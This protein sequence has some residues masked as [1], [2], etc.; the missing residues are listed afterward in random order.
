MPY[1]RAGLE[2]ILPV[3]KALEAILPV[4]KALEA[5]L[6][7]IALFTALPLYGP[8]L[9]HLAVSTV[10]RVTPCRLG[11]PVIEWLCRFRLRAREKGLN[12]LRSRVEGPRG[13][14]RLYYSQEPWNRYTTGPPL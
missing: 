7:A 10:L 2:A 6:P 5:I 12:R 9:P 4:Y 11:T 3:Y 1:R 8:I 13:P 14:S